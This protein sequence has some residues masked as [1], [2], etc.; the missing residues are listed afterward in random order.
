MAAV[1]LDSAGK[2]DAVSLH[3]LVTQL[4]TCNICNASEHITFRLFLG[5]TLPIVKK[6]VT[7]H[8]AIEWSYGGVE[9]SF[10]FVHTPQNYKLGIRMLFVTVQLR[11]CHLLSKIFTYW[12]GNKSSSYMKFNTMP[13]FLGGLFGI[14]IMIK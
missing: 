3:S 6:Y 10:D 5:R 1:Y 4:T 13:S 12:N 2:P 14:M 7:S 9:I 11:I 8:Q